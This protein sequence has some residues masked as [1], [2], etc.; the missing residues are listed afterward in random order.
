MLLLLVGL[1]LLLPQVLHFGRCW[2]RW[3]SA[4]GGADSVNAEAYLNVAEPFAQAFLAGGGV[5]GSVPSARAQGAF[6]GVV[7]AVD[8]CEPM[9]LK[10]LHATY[11]A[12]LLLPLSLLPLPPVCALFSVLPQSPSPTVCCT[13]LP[14]SCHFQH[15]LQRRCSCSTSW[16]Q[17]LHS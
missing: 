14:L 8:V 10:V 11:S 9:L 13:L 5:A 16:S 1:L 7:V 12:R 15:S 17:C 6:Q 3:I 4:H 2:S